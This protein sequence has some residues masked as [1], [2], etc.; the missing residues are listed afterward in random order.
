[1]QRNEV[2]SPDAAMT[3]IVD[4][5]S[6]ESDGRKIMSSAEAE[7]MV[8][9]I[10]LP[11]LVLRYLLQ[12]DVLPL[13]RQVMIYG[14]PGS[15]KSALLSEFY[16]CFMINSGLPVHIENENKDGPDLRNSLLYADANFAKRIRVEQTNTQEE[17]MKAIQRWVST[18]EAQF[19]KIEGRKKKAKKRDDETAAEFKERTKRKV[20]SDKLGYIYPFI[21]GLDSL[22][23]TSSEGTQQKI[24]DEGA[25]TNRFQ[26]EAKFLSDFGKRLPDLFRDKPAVLVT[27][28]HRKDKVDSKTGFVGDRIPGG[29]AMRYMNSTEIRTERISNI[30]QADYGGIRVRLK[31]AKNSLGPTGLS[32]VVTFKWWYEKDP[33]TGLGVQRSGWDWDSATIDL[34]LDYGKKLASRR[35]AVRDVVDINPASARKVWSKTLGIPASKPVDFAKAGAMI[36]A[37]PEILAG[38]HDVLHIKTRAKFVPGIEYGLLKEHM[39]ADSQRNESVYA[40]YRGDMSDLAFIDAELDA[41][42]AVEAKKKARQIEKE[43]EEYDDE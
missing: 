22:T 8:C 34:L 9:G 24:K 31:I 1:M 38:L 7:A 28:N 29:N 2:I 3:A 20:F 17:W 37:N 16:R 4:K 39:L 36:E 21:I 23:A 43:E 26:E 12:Q 6:A 15:A 42:A 35:N 14:D 13:S 25:P 32:A 40:K 30:D 5:M 33:M 10:P 19:A 41:V 27:V 18:Y 11:C